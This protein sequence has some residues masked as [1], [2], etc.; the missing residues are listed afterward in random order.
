M[1]PTAPAAIVDRLLNPLGRLVDAALALAVFAASAAVLTQVVFRYLLDAPVAWLDEFAVLAFAWIIML[2]A[3]VVQRRDAHMQIDS[4]V[5]PL[6][7]G[8]QAAAW[9]MRLLCIAVT[10]AVLLWQG[11]VLAARMSFIQYPAMEISRGFLFAVL[12]VAVPLMLA[13]MAR[14]ALA[15]LGVIRGGG[16]VLDRPQPDDGMADDRS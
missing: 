10:L 12:P 8:L 13:W 16:R 1:G 6:P 9:A 2:G 11:W 5:R 7:A 14:N 3:V 15:D 4:F